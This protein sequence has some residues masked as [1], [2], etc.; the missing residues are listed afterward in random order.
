MYKQRKKIIKKKEI[1]LK[2]HVTTVEMSE[3]KLLWLRDNQS[4]S[5][6]SKNYLEIK[7]TLNLHEDDGMLIRSC[8]RL[9]NAKITFNSKASIMLDRNHKLTELLI[10][11]LHHKVLHRGVKQTLTEF[12]QQ[13]WITRGRSCVKKVI[14]PCIICKKLN[15]RPY[16]YPQH[17]DIPEFRFDDISPFHLVGVDYSGPMMCLPV[18]DVKVKLYKAWVIYTCTSTRAIIL[19]V[20]H[21]YHS[22]TFINCFKGLIAKLGCSS[23]VISDNGKTF[24]SEDTQTFVSNHFINWKFNVKKAPW[25]GGMWERLVSCVKKYIKKVVGTR[26]ITYIELQTLIKEIELILNNCLIDVDYDDDQEDILSPSHLIFGRQLS[27]TNMSTQNSDS[28]LNLSK[29]KKMLQTILNHFWSRWRR[30]YVTSLRQ[31]QKSKQNK[32]ATQAIKKK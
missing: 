22:S 11:Y 5:K 19:D 26:T 27:T 3:V 29:R 6:Q 10:L 32:S 2:S 8:S 21:N 1:I 14:H 9:K 16:L 25:L 23:A 13:Y 15:G 28:D 18:Y 30:E 20:F 24:I 4:Q 17:S 7:I 31:F 12:R